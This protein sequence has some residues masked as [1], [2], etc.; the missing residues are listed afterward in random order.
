[1]FFCVC[2]EAGKLCW[3]LCFFNTLEFFNS[4]NNSYLWA[5]I[6]VFSFIPASHVIGH[7]A[8]SLNGV[9]IQSFLQGSWHGLIV[10]G[11]G[12]S[13]HLSKNKISLYIHQN[14]RAWSLN[15]K[16]FTPKK[17]VILIKTMYLTK[18]LFFN[19]WVLSKSTSYGLFHCTGCVTLPQLCT[20]RAE[21]QTSMWTLT[22]T[23]QW[24]LYHSN[25]S[26]LTDTKSIIKGR[27]S[28]VWVRI[29]L[30]F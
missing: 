24:N 17:I 26:T 11:R 3:K 19:L 18:G 2:K 23:I 20:K 1:M 25:L 12:P 21:K 16:R 15:L 4:S 5:W 8:Q 27:L 30:S 10:L 13:G 14:T 7:V 28:G 29:F 22:L 9:M 6:F